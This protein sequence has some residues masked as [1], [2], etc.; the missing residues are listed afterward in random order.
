M[1]CD[2]TLDHWRKVYHP[3]HL[4]GRKRKSEWLREGARDI[5][6]K[7]HEK[8]EATLARETPTFLSADQLAAMDKLIFKACQELAGGWD[9]SP[10][11]YPADRP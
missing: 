9:P 5:L 11:L 8:V 10:F 3:P 7:A 4:F 6:T 2:V 1:D